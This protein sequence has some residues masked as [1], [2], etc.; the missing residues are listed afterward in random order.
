MCGHG[1]PGSNTPAERR[2]D[3]LGAVLGRSRRH[4]P[5]GSAPSG[6][7]TAQR[8][9][10]RVRRPAG[11][12]G[13]MRGDA[14]RPR[15]GGGH[16]PHP[17]GIRNLGSW[18]TKTWASLTLH[19]CLDKGGRRTGGAR[20]VSKGRNFA[21][22]GRPLDGRTPRRSPA[23]CYVRSTSTPAGRNAS[24]PDMS[25]QARNSLQVRPRSSMLRSRSD[26]RSTDERRSVIRFQTASILASA[27]CIATAKA[28]RS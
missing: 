28:G 2:A 12:D 25:G 11:R 22:P 7:P 23:I 27:S 5:S 16:W 14:D 18:P 4:S 17:A 6:R 8:G 3:R 26:S 21:V 24:T 15:D 20:N 9:E 1:S 19:P 13:A 10:V